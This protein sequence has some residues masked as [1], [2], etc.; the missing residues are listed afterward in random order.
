VAYP[1]CRRSINGPE[2]DKRRSSSRCSSARGGAT[3]VSKE[4]GSST[5][6]VLPGS[7]VIPRDEPLSPQRMQRVKYARRSETATIMDR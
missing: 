5:H 3:L 7:M 2:R 6:S 1:H 4:V